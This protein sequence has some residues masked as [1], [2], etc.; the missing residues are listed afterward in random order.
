[1]CLIK[2]VTNDSIKISRKLSMSDGHSVLIK[3][4]NRTNNDSFKEIYYNII[5]NM[6]NSI[7]PITNVPSNKKRKKC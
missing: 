4:M 5:L 2:D 1:M 7:K 6:T 3:L